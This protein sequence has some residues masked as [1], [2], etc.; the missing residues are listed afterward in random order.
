MKGSGFGRSRR[1]AFAALA[2]PC[3]SGNEEASAYAQASRWQGSRAEEE[4]RGREADLRQQA[5][6][7]CSLRIGN[8]RK[9]AFA[10]FA[11]PCASGNEEASAHAQASRW[12]GSRAEEQ[13]RGREADLRQQARAHCSLQI[14]QQAETRLRGI[15]TSMCGLTAKLTPSHQHLRIFE[16][17]V[18]EFIDPT[19]R[20]ARGCCDP[21]AIVQR[22][23]LPLSVFCEQRQF[24][25]SSDRYRKTAR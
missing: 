15:N 24:E 17:D 8:K 3:A 4:E 20:E 18:V 11:H 14:G 16:G 25:R 23:E 19:S 5:R 13:E 12:Q 10:A 7:H 6:A 2:H 9:R 1:P 22:I 21:T